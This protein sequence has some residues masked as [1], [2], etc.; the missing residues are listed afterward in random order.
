MYILKNLIRSYYQNPVN[1]PRC[2]MT[3]KN[4]RKQKF[5]NL[6]NKNMII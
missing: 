1:T 6:I 2:E 5:N 3:M 4:K